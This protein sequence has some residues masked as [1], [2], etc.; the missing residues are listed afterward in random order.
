MAGEE[1]AA[2]FVPHSPPGGRSDGNVNTIDRQPV[3]AAA[4]FDSS[5]Y[6]CDA[7]IR[8]ENARLVVSVLSQRFTQTESKSDRKMMLS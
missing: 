6:L 3:T 7:T 5:F 8:F 1:V 4:L 2:S